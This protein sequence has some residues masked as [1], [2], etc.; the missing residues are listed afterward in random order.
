MKCNNCGTENVECN[1]F[2]SACGSKLES[3]INKAEETETIKCSK[4]G[5]ENP[6]ENRFCSACGSKLEPATNKAEETITIKCGKCGTE[7]PRESRFCSVCGNRLIAADESA[8]EQGTH[9]SELN[10]GEVEQTSVVK[11]FI[12]PKRGIELDNS[13]PMENKVK[14]FYII[15]ALVC[16]YFIVTGFVEGDIIGSIITGGF[17]GA[18]IFAVIDMTV[19][20][21]KIISM[22]RTEYYFPGRIYDL[23]IIYAAIKN[24][25]MNR[26]FSVKRDKV[27]DDSIDFVKDDYC[28]TLR[29]NK[30]NGTF[31]ISIHKTLEGQLSLKGSRLSFRL[32]GKS[33]VNVP[34]IVYTFQENMKKLD[35]MDNSELNSV[36]QAADSMKDEFNTSLAKEVKGAAFQIIKYSVTVAVILGIGVVAANCYNNNKY[37]NMVK[38]GSPLAYPDKSYG[39]AFKDFF[40]NPK[41]KYFTSDDNRKVVEFTGGMTY[42]DQ[43]VDA[44]I[45][46][47][48]DD[49]YE[50]NVQINMEYVGF[51]DIPQNNL[52]KIAMMSAIF[53]GDGE[54]ETT[55]EG[56]IDTHDG[57]SY[58]DTQEDE[59]WN[60][61]DDQENQDIYSGLPE[62]IQRDSREFENMFLGGMYTGD[63]G[64]GGLSIYSSPTDSEV[65]RAHF[66][67]DG[68]TYEGL[69]YDIGENLFYIETNDGIGAYLSVFTTGDYMTPENIYV[70]LYYDGEYVETY[71]LYEQYIP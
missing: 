35:L 67:S 65:G 46:F 26:G 11:E 17:I 59:E 2:C 14:K 50:D 40:S 32:Y 28:Y 70:N 64:D 41:W 68:V 4:C 18:F 52:M 39:E 56:V 62:Y 58:I 71:N 60:Y 33:L 25:F 10:K 5:T 47:T 66:E 49:R 37:I 21:A 54:W 44:T 30:D 1:Q 16:A 23:D 7:N 8:L 12:K 34:L 20:R 45:Q 61:T 51:N 31:N 69:L 19:C 57:Q 6:S 27:L 29:L 9:I 36:A 13:F 15:P 53:E 48:V 55:T 3:A 43:P 38:V 22:E 24:E 42:I 63:S